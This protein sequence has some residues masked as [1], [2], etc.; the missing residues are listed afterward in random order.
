MM[1]SAEKKVT[2]NSIYTHSILYYFGRQEHGQVQYCKQLCTLIHNGPLMSFLLLCPPRP[3]CPVTFITPK[4]CA[5]G[6]LL[7]QSEGSFLLLHLFFFFVTP[8]AC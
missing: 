8:P 5:L 2:V 6:N 3:L 4:N 7:Q 1:H